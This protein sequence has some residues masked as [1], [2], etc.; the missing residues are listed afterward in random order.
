M[1]NVHYSSSEVAISQGLS[2]FLVISVFDA[3]YLVLFGHISCCCLSKVH[4]AG[5]CVIQLRWSQVTVFFFSFN[6]NCISF[7]SNC[8]LRSGSNL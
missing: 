1:S 6:D 3:S 4:D 8:K 7:A 2:D 5:A